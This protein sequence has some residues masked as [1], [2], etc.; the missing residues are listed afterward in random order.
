[1]KLTL[2]EEMKSPFMNSIQAQR[3]SVSFTVNVVIFATVCEVRL[4]VD[5][6]LFVY[7]DSPSIG[8]YRYEQH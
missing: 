7:A 5:G 4:W 1:M 8:Q 3:S 6:D 2:T